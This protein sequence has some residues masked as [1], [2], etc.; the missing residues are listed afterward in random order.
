[1]VAAREPNMH[2]LVIGSQKHG[3]MMNV[4]FA[5]V[6][7]VLNELITTPNRAIG[8]CHLVRN[9]NWRVLSAVNSCWSYAHH[10][11]MIESQ[12]DIKRQ[13]HV[14]MINNIFYRQK[15]STSNKNSRAQ[16]TRMQW[17]NLKKMLTS[18]TCFY[19][20]SRGGVEL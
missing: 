19:V 18:Y 5:G 2:E 4:M 10:V 9:T 20:P 8:L 16:S 6:S 15:S 13:S 12:R 7:V 1:M 14:E 3:F 17:R 11:I